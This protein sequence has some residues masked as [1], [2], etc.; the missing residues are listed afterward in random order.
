[1]ELVTGAVEVVKLSAPPPSKRHGVVE[2]RQRER[3]REEATV[4]RGGHC[5]FAVA[6]AKLVCAAG[7]VERSVG[8]DRFARG[9]PVLLCVL[10]WMDGRVDSEQ[11]EKATAVDFIGYGAFLR[12]APLGPRRL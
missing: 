2:L 11:R 12:D 10:C 8:N 3:Q 7:S 9:P 4:C 6:Q 5:C 1:M